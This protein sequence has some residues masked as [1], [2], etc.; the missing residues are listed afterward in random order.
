MNGF[1]GEYNCKLDSKYRL[2]VP[3]GLSKQLD[4]NDQ[5]QFVVNR[6]LNGCINLYPVSEWAKVMEGLR[7]L[8]RFK[9]KNLEFIRKFQNGA[10]KVTI[11]GSGRILLPKHLIEYAGISKEVVLSSAIDQIEIWDKATYSNMMQSNN[12]DFADLAEEVMGD[13]DNDK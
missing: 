7:K 1:I 8:N 9:A 2:S 3:S 5:D 11:D 10:T 13:L 12:D 4:P 6:G